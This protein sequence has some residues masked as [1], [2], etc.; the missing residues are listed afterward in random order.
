MNIKPIRNDDDLANALARVEQLWGAAM[1]SPAGDELEILAVLIEKYEEQH[2]P[3]PASDPIDAIKFRMD[4]QGLAPRDLLPSLAAGL[5]LM[6]ALRLAV[7]GGASLYAPQAQNN[8][9][10]VA[11]EALASVLGGVQSMFTAAWDEPFALPS[12]ESATLALRTQQVIAY[13]SGLADVVDAW[14][15]CDAFDAAKARAIQSARGDS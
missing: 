5:L 9:V 15:V 11:Y 1:G 4:Q 13:E 12:E 8:L 10:R 7:S 3:L 14:E 6:A 2:Q